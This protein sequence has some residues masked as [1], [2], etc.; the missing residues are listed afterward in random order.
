MAYQIVTQRVKNGRP[1]L[2][3]IKVLEI[4]P[5]D[6]NEEDDIDGWRNYCAD[7]CGSGKFWIMWRTNFR[8]RNVLGR[9]NCV[10]VF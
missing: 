8:A 9:G 3:T 5:T 2:E 7:Y 6:I 4:L 10:E 1:I